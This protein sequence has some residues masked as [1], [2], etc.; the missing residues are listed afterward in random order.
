MIVRFTQNYVSSIKP[1]PNKPLWIT[2]ALT[3]NLKL[4]VGT[5]GAKVWYV[6]YRLDGRKASHKLGPAGEVITV[7]QARD[8]ANDFI[9]RLKRGENPQKK[10]LP[11]ITFGEFLTK[12]YEEWILLNHGSGKKTLNMLRSRFAFLLP[13]PLEEI[14]ENDIEKWRLERQ[15]AGVKA[16]TIN[17]CTASL[18]SAFSW[19]VKKGL[20]DSNPLSRLEKLKERDS[21][22]KVRYLS[23]DERKRL[24]A[25]LDARE[26][27]LR[28]RRQNH[29]QH[30]AGREYELMPEPN[31]N[32]AD[33]LKPM[34]LVS[35]NTGIRQNNLFSLEWRDIDFESQTMTLRAKITKSKKT[36]MLPI[37]SVVV[38]TLTVWRE[39][40][41][42]TLP[43]ALVFP[44]PKSGGKF[45]NCKKA[46]AGLM[47]DAEITNFR[48]HDMRHDFAS[49]LVMKGVDL[50]IV[51]ELMGHASLTMTLRYAHL[52]PANKLR[53]AEMLATI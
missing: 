32:F 10:Q 16:A 23:E 50:N 26:K 43:N 37:N 53:A 5:S 47:V 39:Q 52:A 29:N 2:D 14:H 18:R 31:G 8:M 19:A 17:R 1:D 38:K 24:M 30:H 7:A 28:S 49:Q 20:M 36:T 51:R 46:W 33:Y 40:S 41:Q 11:K 48:W 45:D 12:E 42:D 3:D 21:D 44:S 35:L 9:S 34:I 22:V 4:Y 25:A 27:Q 15:K 6:Y 13:R